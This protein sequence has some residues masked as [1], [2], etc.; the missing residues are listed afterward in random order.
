MVWDAGG[1]NIAP[2]VCIGLRGGNG[3]KR[4]STKKEMYNG[5]GGYGRKMTDLNREH[6]R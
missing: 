4:G 3:V 1:V 6:P 5:G 2:A